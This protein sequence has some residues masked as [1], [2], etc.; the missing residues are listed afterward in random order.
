[1][2]NITKVQKNFSILT[3]LETKL[4]VSEATCFSLLSNLFLNISDKEKSP[5]GCR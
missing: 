1:M 5:V 3:N 2:S 4:Y